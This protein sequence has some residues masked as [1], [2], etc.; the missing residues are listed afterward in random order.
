MSELAIHG[1]SEAAANL[2]VPK[3]RRPTDASWQDV[4]DSLETGRGCRTTT[5]GNG[6]CDRFE[7]AFAA[8]H[9]AEHAIA[10]A[11]ETVTI[12]LALRAVGVEPG[13]EVIVLSYLFIASASVVPAV[14]T[15]ARFVD[16]D[17]KTYNIDLDHLKE[18]ITDQTA[19]SLGPTSPSIR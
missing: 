2:T 18:V 16:M 11:N 19:G 6:F 4:E 1:G 17:P 7:T 9:D 3:W 12:E 13:D 8:Y 14:G 10:V 15:I 5:D